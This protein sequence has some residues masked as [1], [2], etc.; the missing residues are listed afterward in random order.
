MAA[1]HETV[2]E[3]LAETDARHA[4]IAPA[5]RIKLEHGFADNV[6]EPR[7]WAGRAEGTGWH[8]FR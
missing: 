2:W 5:T 1:N 6:V 3:T 7:R 4:N 8:F